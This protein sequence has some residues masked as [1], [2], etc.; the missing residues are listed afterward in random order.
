VLTVT[1]CIRTAKMNNVHME[2]LS[3]EEL[4]Q[5]QLIVENARR[6]GWLKPDSE[7]IAERNESSVRVAAIRGSS[8]VERTY[9]R[10]ERWQYQLV[11]DLAWGWYGAMAPTQ[12]G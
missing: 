11:R 9:P 1:M 3:A 6:E 8:V 12:P 2:M 5:F 4:G 10:D 7:L